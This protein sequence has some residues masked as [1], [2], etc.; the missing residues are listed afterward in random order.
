MQM[1][2][3][4]FNE[5]VQL[6]QMDKVDTIFCLG[7]HVWKHFF[8]GVLVFYESLRVTY[9]YKNNYVHL[10]QEDLTVRYYSP[11]RWTCSCPLFG[12]LVQNGLTVWDCCI[13]S[14]PPT[15]FQ[16]L[17]VPKSRSFRFAISET[18]TGG[19]TM[20]EKRLIEIR[21]ARQV[22]ADILAITLLDMVLEGKVRFESDDALAQN[23]SKPKLESR[24]LPKDSLSCR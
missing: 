18:N 21:E 23:D 15:N 19:K 7:P 24:T 9:I 5:N 11:F 17:A 2:I 3:P 6:P 13:N 4:L 14:C 10:V 20:E 1:S 12:N 8:F 22:V 16:Q